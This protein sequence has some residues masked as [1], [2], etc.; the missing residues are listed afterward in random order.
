MRRFDAAPRRATPKGHKSF[1]SCTAA[2]QASRLP[3]Y[4]SSLRA[5]RTNARRLRVWCAKPRAS[6]CIRPSDIQQARMARTRLLLPAQP[7][8]FR[9]AEPP[10]WSRTARRI[11]C[12]ARM[13]LFEVS[14]FEEPIM[15]VRETGQPHPGARSSRPESCPGDGSQAHPPRSAKTRSPGVRTPP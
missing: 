13:R 2:L 1:I 9:R 3:T 4:D 15:D 6:S 8:P 10:P 5:W 7:R 14:N 11:C 12:P